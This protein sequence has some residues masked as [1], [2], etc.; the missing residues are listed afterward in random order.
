MDVHPLNAEDRQLMKRLL[1]ATLT[2]SILSTLLVVGTA[3]T[4]APETDATA[5]ATSTTRPP[6]SAT[7][8]RTLTPL[9]AS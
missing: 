6:P 1:A 4:S 3:T 7:R 9:L 2:A 5:F 8:G